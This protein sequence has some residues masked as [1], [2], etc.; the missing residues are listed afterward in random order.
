MG[1]MMAAEFAQTVSTTP[2]ESIAI[3]ANPSTTDLTKRNGK[4][5]MFAD[6]SVF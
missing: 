4:K 2:K 5:S 1:S 3:N 6:V